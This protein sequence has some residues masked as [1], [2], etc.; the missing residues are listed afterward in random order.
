[1]RA[2]AEPVDDPS[3]GLR[4]GEA[5]ALAGAIE[6]ACAQGGGVDQREGEC[7]RPAAAEVRDR[8][9]HCGRAHITSHQP[10]QQGWQAQQPQGDKA[11]PVLAEG[12][13]KQEAV[14]APEE[15]IW[16]ARVM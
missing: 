3:V 1:M 2:P 15:K 14:K 4:I 13:V 6:L 7:A 5:L 12:N 11:R 16:D 10:D 9:Q 8:V